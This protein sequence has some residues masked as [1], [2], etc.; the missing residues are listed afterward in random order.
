MTVES[1]LASL[2]LVSVMAIFTRR[3]AMIRTCAAIFAA[4]IANYSYIMLTG[5]EYPVWWFV[6]IDAIVA[7]II[8]LKPAGRIQGW[9]GCCF[10]VQ[11]CINMGL[12]LAYWG[13]AIPYLAQVKAWSYTTPIGYIKLALIGAWALHDGTRLYIHHLRGRGTVSRFSDYSGT[14]VF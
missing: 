7:R 9:I 12:G 3:S 6:A 8:L 14:G 4:W 2:A 5:S 1:Y 10:I 11:V 13:E